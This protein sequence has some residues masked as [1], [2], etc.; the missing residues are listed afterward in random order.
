M[1]EAFGIA[2]GAA[3]IAAAFTACVDCFEYVQFGR[4]FGRD[5]QTDL[6]A[7]NCSR[8]RL[9]HWG[10]AVDILNNP[11]LG[12]PD[13]TAPEIRT[14]KDTL[15]QILVLFA[16]S[17]KISQ[18]YRLN[19]TASEDLSV[20][21]S[22]KMD[23]AIITLSNKMR[24][25][26]IKRQKSSNILRISQWA[27]YRRSE[28]KSLV[29]GIS[30]LIDS[31]EKIFPAP[32]AQLTLVRQE[33]AQLHD[34]RALELVETTAEGV[35]GLLQNAA[36]KVLNGHRY[37]NVSIKGKAQAGDAFSSDW[38][39][40]AAGASHTYDGVIVDNDGKA[41]IGNKYGGKDFWDD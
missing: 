38:H 5:Y 26:A 1:A 18:Q 16:D 12:R 24:E 30:S 39:G 34:R 22:D 14:V 37:L 19:A 9:T 31:I 2:A 8:I 35:D 3:G 33:A 25:L 13:A 32:Q 23:S 41:L 4:H 17:A 15:C 7:L 11:K 36:R 27:L 40:K 28:F 10:Q 29:E 21:S 6:L 20:L